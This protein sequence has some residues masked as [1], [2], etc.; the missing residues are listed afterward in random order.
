MSIFKKS[1]LIN[2]IAFLRFFH[3]FDIRRI[4]YLNVISVIVNGKWGG[5][6]SYNACSKKCGGGV[7]RRL[8]SC[9]S[10]A[11]AYGGAACAGSAFEIKACNTHHCPG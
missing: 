3:D 10:P 5:W 6:G 8:R 4:L 7:Q 2:Q 1:W 9:N 11:P